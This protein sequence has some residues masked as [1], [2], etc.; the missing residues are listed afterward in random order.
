MSNREIHI[1]S[2]DYK[3]FIKQIK[4]QIHS[5]QIKV[6]ISVNRG[7]LKLYWF[8]GSEIVKNQKNANWGDGLVKQVSKDLQAEFL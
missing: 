8:I 5:S 7:M 1:Q 3:V 2:N 4:N 6:A